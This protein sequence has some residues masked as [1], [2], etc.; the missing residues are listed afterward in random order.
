MK[1]SY[2][3]LFI[4][5]LFLSSVANLSFAA[6]TKNLHF[7]ARVKVAVKADDDIKNTVT[8]YVYRELRSLNYVELVSNEPEWEISIVAMAPKLINGSN[9]IG[10]TLSTV[11]THHVEKL[12]LSIM[13]KPELK[14][15]DMTSAFL[16]G[17]DTDHL[18]YVG[19]T[20]DLQNL[21]KD[22]VAEFDTKVEENRKFW[23][24]MIESQTWF[25]DAI[26]RH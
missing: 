15:D 23:R 11:I 19:A 10:V 3:L 17:S 13:L 4:L 16:W 8:S 20:D 26:K 21:C 2:F 5:A 9:K 18:L 1:K 6:D 14:A 7:S 22:I 12:M 24:Q 25:K